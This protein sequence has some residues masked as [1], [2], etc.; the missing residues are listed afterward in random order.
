MIFC[1]HCV[2]TVFQLP[3]PDA[4]YSRDEE[5]KRDVGGYLALFGL[6]RPTCSQQAGV[7]EGRKEATK[8]AA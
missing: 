6:A 2:G 4:A 3:S 7:I 8:P 1:E 5:K